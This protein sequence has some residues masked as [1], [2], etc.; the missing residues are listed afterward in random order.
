MLPPSSNRRRRPAWL[1]KLTVVIGLLAA[2]V[3]LLA[4]LHLSLEGHRF[5]AHRHG[6]VHAHAGHGPAAAHHR[7]WAPPAASDRAAQVRSQDAHEAHAELCAL[8][9]QLAP[10]ALPGVAAPLQL[11]ARRYATAPPWAPRSAAFAAGVL[12]FAPKTSPPA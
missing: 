11:R 3:Q 10:L 5:D 8:L 6:W 9:D 1:R 2:T 7:D 12:A 4:G